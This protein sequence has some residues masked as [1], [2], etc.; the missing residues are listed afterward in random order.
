MDINQFIEK[1]KVLPVRSARIEGRGGKL[2]SEGLFSEEIFGRVGSPPRKT[3][4]GYVDL[5]VHIIHPE[6]WDMII[7]LNP[8]IGKIATGKK[9][10]FIN[11]QGDFEESPNQFV[12]LSG[13]KDLIDNWDKL[14]LSLVGKKHPE[15]VKFLKKNREKIFIDKMLILPAGIRDIQQSKLTS[16]KMV[17]S[18][19]INRFYDE[20][21]QQTKAI[22]KSIFEF[23]DAET[24]KNIVGAV[25]RKVLEINVWIRERLKGKGGLIRGGLLRKTVDYS[26]RANIVGDPS[27][28]VGYIGLPWQIVLK[29]YEPFVE[30]QIL[31]NPFNIHVRDMIKAYTGNEKTLSSSDLKRFLVMINEQP[32][33]VDPTLVDELVR[34]AEEIVKN[35]VIIYKRDPVENRSSY[36]SGYIR[37]DRDSFV[38][39]LNT[40]DT[41]RMGADFDKKK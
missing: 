7:G 3:T 21:L 31:R 14:N 16:K 8:A 26:G 18:S 32:E 1:N 19:E 24:I 30:Y 41:I 4:F 36:L 40:L 5:N 37:V 34:V 28:K 12:G 33:L 9:R 2:D 25:Q 15:N 39:R 17:T 6:V 23:L 13:I 10:Y 29:L 20:L 38:I 11:E 22:D 35:K 27:L